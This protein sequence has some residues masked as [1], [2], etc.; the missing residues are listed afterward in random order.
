MTRRYLIACDNNGHEW[1]L[2]D[3]KDALAKGEW[4]DIERARKHLEKDG[5]GK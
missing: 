5:Q 4:K 1:L 2:F 3:A